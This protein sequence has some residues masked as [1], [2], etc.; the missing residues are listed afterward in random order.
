[1]LNESAVQVLSSGS[2]PLLMS[3]N[4]PSAVHNKIVYA[5]PGMSLAWASLY[6]QLFGSTH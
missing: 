5:G 3:D 4:E 2:K 6:R 1:M